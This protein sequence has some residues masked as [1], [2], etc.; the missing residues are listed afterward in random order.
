MSYGF[1]VLRNEH[2]EEINSDGF[3]YEHAS[4]AK[5]IYL[6]NNDNNKVFSVTFKT[7]PYDNTGVAHIMEHSVLCG[8]RNYRVKDPFNELKKGSI[9]TYLNAM[10]FSDKTMYPVASTNEKDFI[11]LINVYLDAVFFPLIYEYKEIFLQEGWHYEGNDINGVV[12]NEMKGAFSSPEKIINTNLKKNLFKDNNYKFY[13]GGI[14]EFIPELKYKEFINFHKNYYHPSNSIIYLYGDIDID[15]Y[16][17]IIDSKYLG[18]FNKSYITTNYVIQ[19]GSKNILYNEDKYFLSD[20]ENTI[21]KNY[22][23]AGFCI[24]NSLNYELTMNFNILCS[25]LLNM[26]SSPLKRIFIEKNLGKNII[27]S[28]ENGMYQPIFCI[29]AEKTDKIDLEYFKNI[30]YDSL[31]DLIFKGIEKDVING[32]INKTKFYLKEEDFGYKPKGLFYNIMLMQSFIYGECSFEAIKFNKIFNKIKNTNYTNLID[33]YILNNNNCAFEMLLAVNIYDKKYKTTT[34]NKKNNNNDDIMLKKYQLNEDE[35]KD[36]ENIPMLNLSD[37]SKDIV[38]IPFVV[39]EISSSKVVYSPIESEELIYINMLFS[40]STIP[41]EFIGYIS[42]FKYLLGKL[43]TYKYKNDELINKINLYIGNLDFGF[44]N[45]NNSE[46]KYSAFFSIKVK[47]LKENIDMF[48]DL[49][50]QIVF[51]TIFK[52]KEYI[53]KLIF[54]LKAN[55]EKNFIFDSSSYAVLRCNSYFSE[56]HKYD[57]EIKGIN[58]YNFITHITD[59]INE[60]IDMVLEN[61]KKLSDYIFTKQN[62]ILGISSNKSYYSEIFSKCKSFYHDLS[63]KILE[64]NRIKFDM[65][66]KNEAFILNSKVQYNVISSNFKKFGYNYNGQFAVLKKIINTDYL[67]DSIRVKGGAYG[68]YSAFLRNGI[69]YIYSY[70]DPKLK[71]TYESYKNIYKYIENI[72]LNEREIKKYIIG[73][74]SMLDKPLKNNDIGNICLNRYISGISETQLLNEREKILN[75]NNNSIRKYAQLIYNCI[76]ENYICTFGIENNI[77][78]NNNLFDNIVRLVK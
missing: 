50:Y 22:M 54:E 47:L 69:M 32:C 59:N 48:F 46:D 7:L 40:T 43:D 16:L 28:F 56:M 61:L 78:K 14:P 5:L 63:N 24:G 73:T 1:K 49:L 9:N 25:V 44:S 6:K 20:K 67:W 72:N 52:D 68:A 66:I 27:A 37:I 18:V 74:I 2:L 10:T 53:K 30:I 75:I 3:I 60:N 76:N 15:K 41:F 8:S 35:K 62:F 29:N 19:E 31:K 38:H 57:D 17:E 71:E 4:G 55:I 51:K 77:Q 64:E 33:E 12:Y 42:I 65:N 26:P 23:S 36:I 13:S 34:F 70:R 58:F 45:Y 11:N 21:Q 39:D